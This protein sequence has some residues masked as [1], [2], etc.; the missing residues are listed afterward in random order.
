[1]TRAR[2]EAMKAAKRKKLEA[3][4]WKVGGVKEFLG[5]T[6]EEMALVE[7]KV[8]LVTMLKGAREAKGITQAKLAKL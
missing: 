1:M 5:L 2:S 8:R 6:D 3:A 7:M 4:G